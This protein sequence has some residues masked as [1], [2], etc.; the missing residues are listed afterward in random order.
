MTPED[1]A[2]C[3]Q[4]WDAL[5]EPERT[6]WMERAQ[7][8]SLDDAWSFYKKVS[9]VRMLQPAEL[10]GLS[11]EMQEA[12]RWMAGELRRRRGDK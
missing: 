3:Q 6:L 12:S 2:A 11:Q 4:W 9:P 5:T 7:A 10:A 1:A 8:S